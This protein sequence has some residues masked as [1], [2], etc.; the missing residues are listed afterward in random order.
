MSNIS[1]K[2]KE[3][4]IGDVFEQAYLVTEKFPPY[5]YE[6]PAGFLHEIKRQSLSLNETSLTN[7]GNTRSKILTLANTK[8]NATVKGIK[9]QCYFYLLTSVY[10]VHDLISF[11]SDLAY[12]AL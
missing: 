1:V 7:K 6:A 5:H 3:D 12:G 11:S 4:K 9:I 2:K 8:L 10:H